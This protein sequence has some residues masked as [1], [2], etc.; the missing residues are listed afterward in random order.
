[1]NSGYKSLE[2]CRFLPTKKNKRRYEIDNQIKATLKDMIIR[3]QRKLKSGK[4]EDDLLSLLLH[5]QNL[6]DNDMT[7]DDVMEECKLFY[8][9][10]QETT[11]NWLTWTMIVLSMHPTWQDRARAEVVDFFGKSTPDVKTL[12]QLKIV[13]TIHV[14][15]FYYSSRPIWKIKYRH[16]VLFKCA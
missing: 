13:S 10:G 15:V 8:F 11:A 16:C 12:N 5:C 7:I 6:T 3:K 4:T 9:A 2:I 14:H 1:M